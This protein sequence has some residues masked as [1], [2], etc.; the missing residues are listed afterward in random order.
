VLIPALPMILAEVP[1]AVVL[2]DLLEAL[3]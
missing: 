2:R 1:I 3:H